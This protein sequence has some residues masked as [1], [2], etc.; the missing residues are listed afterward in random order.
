MSIG[1]AFGLWAVELLVI[2]ALAASRRGA[3]TGIWIAIAFL[4]LPA[5]V[6]EPWWP[7]VA[8]LEL[9]LLFA[10]FRAADL[11]SDRTIA[12]FPRRLAHL[13]SLLDKRRMV[14]VPRHFD[15]RA[16]LR[17]ALGVG[18]TLAA[19]TIVAMAERFDGWRHY[20]LRW[21][22]GGAPLPFSI[23]EALDGLI[24]FV[25]AGFGRSFPK[26]NRAPWMATSLSDFWSRRWNSI[27]NTLLRDH[28]LRR[29]AHRGA[30]TAMTAAFV[31]SAALHAY[32]VGMLLGPL[33]TLA[34]TVFFLAQPV[35]MW[36]ERR[37]RV[38]RWRPARGRAWTL[39]AL[40]ALYPLFIEPVLVLFARL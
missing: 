37:L 8:L 34:W 36:I 28:V 30:V 20:A 22:L 26:V 6:A 31:A 25:L 15:W 29:V 35:A 33:A 2:A 27:V 10:M 19:L 13:V 24:A 7:A 21:Y 39:G 40:L 12:T 38:R 16:L 18:I 11:A 3:R 5:F 23:F 1:W 4:P 32:L 14:R 9:G 17:I